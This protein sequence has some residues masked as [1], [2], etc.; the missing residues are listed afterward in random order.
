MTAALLIG[1]ILILIGIA[2]VGALL[3]K[4]RQQIQKLRASQKDVHE[5][6][7][8]GR[9]HTSKVADEIGRRE[10]RQIESFIWLRDLLDLDAPLA[11]MRGWAAS[12]DLLLN[13][14]QLIKTTQPRI[15]LECGGGTSTVVMAKLASTYGG[16]VITL[17]HL[18]EYRDETLAALKLHGVAQHAELRLAPLVEIPELA[19]HGERFRW[20]DPTQLR[21]LPEIDLFFIDGPPE[22]TGRYARYPALPLLWGRASARATVLLDDTIRPDEAEISAAWARDFALTATIWPMEKGAILLSR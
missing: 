11:S 4:Q 13:L 21:D 8:R 15:I 12:P 14:A 10:F 20:Y 19:F 2:G 22:S 5:A 6:V 1:E 17:E 18:P 9:V 3:Y 16:R 7:K